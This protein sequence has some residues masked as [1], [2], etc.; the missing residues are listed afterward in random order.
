MVHARYSVWIGE[1]HCIGVGISYEALLARLMEFT[2]RAAHARF[3]DEST[4][5]HEQLR[6]KGLGALELFHNARAVWDDPQTFAEELAEAKRE[7]AMRRFR[8]E[9]ELDPALYERL[10]DDLRARWRRLGYETSS[11]LDDMK[12]LFAELERDVSESTEHA[13]KR[14]LDG[15]LVAL[16]GD[17]LIP[18]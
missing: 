12:P 7:N 9:N 8:G 17:A 18:P 5:E 15:L 10:D 13:R 16:Q 4:W 6:R 3:A 11:L 2:I 1:T 14:L